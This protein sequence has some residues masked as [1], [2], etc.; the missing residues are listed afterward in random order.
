MSTGCFHETRRQT[1]MRLRAKKRQ[2]SIHNP[3][4]TFSTLARHQ[5]ILNKKRKMKNSYS[6]LLLVLA[7]AAT[8]LPTYDKI[9]L[10]Q[11]SQMSINKPD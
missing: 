11:T 4:I 8:I 2:S 9:A 10:I 3:I 1:A 6:P 5:P 7:L